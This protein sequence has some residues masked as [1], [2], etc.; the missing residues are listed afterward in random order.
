MHRDSNIPKHDLLSRPLDADEAELFGLYLRLKTLAAREDLAPCVTAN[1][2]Q[3]MVM[4]WNVCVDLNLTYE[5]P[6]CD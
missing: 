5:E 4:L 3:A 6:R 1:V 2:R